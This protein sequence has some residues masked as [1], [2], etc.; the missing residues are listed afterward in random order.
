MIIDEKFR[1]KFSFRRNT[2]PKVI[3]GVELTG[4]EKFQIQSETNMEVLEIGQN[5]L[6]EPTNS[7]TDSHSEMRFGL[8]RSH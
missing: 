2:T 7:R 4:L 3:N 1:S 6:I 5:V 8:L